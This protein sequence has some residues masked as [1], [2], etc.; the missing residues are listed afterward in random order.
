LYLNKTG[1][2]FQEHIACYQKQQKKRKIK[3]ET[4]RLK[5]FI[6]TFSQNPFFCLIKKRAFVHLY[7]STALAFK[8]RHHTKALVKPK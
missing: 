8:V 4:N 5:K 7:P 2:S 6:F 1:A 3:Q